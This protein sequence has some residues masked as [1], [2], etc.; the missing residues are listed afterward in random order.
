MD[1]ESICAWFSTNYSTIKDFAAP[2]AT[3]IAAVIAAG[4]TAVF[5]WSHAK[6]A[7]TQKDIALDRLRYD[8]FNKSYT[9]YEATNQLIRITLNAS[10]RIS[11]LRPYRYMVCYVRHHFFCRR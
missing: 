1:L 6:T 10:Q 8:L 2:G 5:A 3:I 7:R 11:L 4:I 9:L